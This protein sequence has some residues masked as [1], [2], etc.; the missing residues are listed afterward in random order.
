MLFSRLTIMKTRFVIPLAATLMAAFT[1]IGCSE[2][3]VALADLPPAA[4]AAIKV[5]IGGLSID[6]IEKKSEKGQVV[7][8]VE[9]RKDGMKIEFE[10]D[11]DG[12]PVPLERD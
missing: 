1:L 10:V 2:S 12:K 6:E 5:K 4:Q 11:K 9:F 8:K 7:Y 3:K